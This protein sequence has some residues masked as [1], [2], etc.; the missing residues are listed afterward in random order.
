ME[1][2]LITGGSGKIGKELIAKIDTSKYEIRILSR[3]KKSIDGCNCLSK[4]DHKE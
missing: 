3:S 2:V 1:T 4:C